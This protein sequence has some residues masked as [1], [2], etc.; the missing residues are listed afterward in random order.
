MFT[1]YFNYK[2]RRKKKYPKEILEALIR[3]IQSQS[4]DLLILSGDITNVSHEKE[5]MVAREILDPLLDDRAFII[6][7]NHDRYIESAINP[8]DL[9]AKYFHPYLGE[10]VESKGYIRI[11][12]K[13]N[14]CVM[15][16]DSNFASGIGNAS[17]KVSVD[18]ITDSFNYLRKE[19]I[20]KY[21]LVCHHPLWN[22]MGQ[23][24]SLMH[25]MI[26]R[27][28][29]IQKLKEMPPISYLHGHKHS[30]FFRK[31]DSEIPF[32][33]IN[34]ASSTM[35]E[36][37]KNHSGYHSLELNS[38]KLIVKRYAYSDMTFKEATPIEY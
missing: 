9:F 34:S 29:V 23:E 35:I 32:A 1:G 16:W 30:N 6:P 12:K 27:E 4:Y 31:P 24:E 19:N 36:T 18:I 17:G 33:I 14:L 21:I 22:P 26:N 13:E 15:G 5:F 38:E 37:K 20:S 11:K 25:R 3:H 28:E 10:R 2:L 7:G 8:I